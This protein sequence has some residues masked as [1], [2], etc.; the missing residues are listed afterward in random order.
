[1][2]RSLAETNELAGNPLVLSKSLRRFSFTS[3]S[4]GPVAEALMLPALVSAKP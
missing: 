1:M 2:P 4:E 3:N